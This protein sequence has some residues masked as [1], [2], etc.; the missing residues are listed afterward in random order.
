MFKEGAVNIFPSVREY[1]AQLSDKIKRVKFTLEQAM[2][3]QSS[4]SGIAL[5]FLQPPR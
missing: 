2:E 5:L 1:A 4:S 3:A